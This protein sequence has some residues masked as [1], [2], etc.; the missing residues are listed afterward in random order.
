[1]WQLLERWS[2]VSW[3]RGMAGARKLQEAAAHRPFLG[4]L[5]GVLGDKV[6]REVLLACALTVVAQLKFLHHLCS[7]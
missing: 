4:S 1:M 5:Q 3:T 6:L 2:P 7:S